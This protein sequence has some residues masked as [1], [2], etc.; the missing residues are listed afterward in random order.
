MSLHSGSAAMAHNLDRFDFRSD[1]ELVAAEALRLAV[2]PETIRRY[3]DLYG[4]EPVVVKVGRL[5][6]QMPTFEAEVRWQVLG[7]HIGFIKQVAHAT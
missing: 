2:D 1:F 6:S 4:D 3:R 7:E 5:L